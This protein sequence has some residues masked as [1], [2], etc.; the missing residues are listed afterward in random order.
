MVLQFNPNKMK[1]HKTQKEARINDIHT[2][3][4]IS[5][6]FYIYQKLSF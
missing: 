3:K 2:L 4:F 1:G 6:V 5:R